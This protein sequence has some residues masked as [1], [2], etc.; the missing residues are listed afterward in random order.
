MVCSGGQDGQLAQVCDEEL[1]ANR[2]P[3][4]DVGGV[5]S[6]LSP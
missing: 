5:S 4:D 2:V 1:A 6:S 3:A